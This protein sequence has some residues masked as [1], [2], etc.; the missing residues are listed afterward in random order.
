MV[1]LLDVPPKATL[2]VPTSLT[3]TVRNCHPSRSA[4]LTI[5]L[6]P[7]SLNSFIV[8]GLRNGRM[9]VLLPGSEEKLV[10]RIIPIECGYVKIP[11]IRVIDR[12]K[13]IPVS[14]SSGEPG[15]APDASTGDLV[16]VVDVR[17]D[18][19]HAAG[20]QSETEPAEA[21]EV[22]ADDTILVLP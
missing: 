1:A 15:A 7:D 13:A 6:E 8:S 9:P 11:R 17:R 10:W 4:N 12:R 5:H 19:R 14:Q 22:G 16:K 18:N 2:H 21:E 20:S 3:L